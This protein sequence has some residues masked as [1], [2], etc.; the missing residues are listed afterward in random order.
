M[1]EA[2]IIL[3]PLRLEYTPSVVPISVPL[4]EGHDLMIGK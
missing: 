4:H 2:K 1:N 3:M